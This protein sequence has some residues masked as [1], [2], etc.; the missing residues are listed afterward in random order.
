MSMMNN[1]IRQGIPGTAR[2]AS[3]VFTPPSR[4]MMRNKLHAIALLAGLI[5]CRSSAMMLLVYDVEVNGDFEFGVASPWEGCTVVSNADFAFHGNWYAQTLPDT[6]HAE[7]FQYL[8]PG[9]PDPDLV[10]YL[11]FY[12]RNGDPGYPNVY[13][14]LSAKRED[15]SF[16]L[17]DVLES[18]R[19]PVAGTEWISYEY[20]FAFGESPMDGVSLKPSIHFE[21][22]A[23]NSVAFL[24][25]VY[26]A[27]D[28]RSTRL[29]G[30]TATNGTLT[31]AI[32]HLAP[33]NRFSI[34]RNLTLADDAW[35]TIGETDLTNRTTRWSEE[36]SNRWDKAYY[37]LRKE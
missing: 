32:D 11:Y 1:G 10:Y 35:T 26:L 2:P 25:L 30:V 23:S 12:A 14:A 7:I 22:G 8:A 29:A 33:T 13:G 5:A 20:V 28:L 9:T 24:D 4:R 34:Q 18:S 19:A 37:R 3:F 27:A 6:P 31:L 15:G 21:G 36:I 17:A 16:I